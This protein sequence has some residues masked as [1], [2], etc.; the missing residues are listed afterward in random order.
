M[1]EFGQKDGLATEYWRWENWCKVWNCM[2]CTVLYASFFRMVYGIYEKK[3]SLLLPDVGIYFP[4]G[5]GALLYMV[6]FPGS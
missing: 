2:L 3:E 4:I 6:H 1:R 5:Q